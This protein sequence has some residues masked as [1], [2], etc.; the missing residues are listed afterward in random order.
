MT[1][2]FFLAQMDRME[3]LKFRPAEL[4]TH[5]E[6]LRDMPDVLLSA[7]V[8]KA[9]RE[10]D[11]FPS[12]KMLRMYADQIRSRVIPLGP[13]PD[14]STPTEPKSV[15]LPTGKVIP[16][17]REWKY[18]CESCSDTGWRSWACVE[19]AVTRQ[20][21]LPKMACGREVDHAAHE[22]AEPCPCAEKDAYGQIKNPAVRRKRERDVQ[23]AAQR[24]RAKGDAA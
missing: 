2:D 14:R 11:E 23:M 22:W 5:W 6:A 3:G 7:A 10:S 4:R 16:F 19:A 21:W 18:Y 24:N 9:Q 12:P 1:W 15:T 13:A 20:P 17:D 8:E